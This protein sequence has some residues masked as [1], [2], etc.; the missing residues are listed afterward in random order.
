MLAPCSASPRTST[1]ATARARSPGRD[2]RTRLRGRRGL[3]DRTH[4]DY[5]DAAPRCALAEWLDDTRLRLHSH[6]RA[7]RRASLRERRR[8]ATRLDASARRRR[9]AAQGR[10]RRDAAT[11]RRGRRRS[12][13][14]RW[15]V[16]SACPTR[17]ARPATTAARRCG[18]AS[19]SSCRCAEQSAC[20][21]ALEVIPNALSTPRRWCD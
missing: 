1:S 8:G 19:R 10:G 16:H 7:D 14:R 21:L 4:F 17:Q 18:A 3:R 12:L 5:H 2:R 15:C 9:G 11:A 13:S 20:E 6:A